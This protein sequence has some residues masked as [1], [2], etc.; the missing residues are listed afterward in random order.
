M[1]Y[2]N[3]AKLNLAIASL[4]AILAIFYD[5][6]RVFAL[7][8]FL[9][10]LGIY[11]YHAFIKKDNFTLNRKKAF[12]TILIALIICISLVVITYFVVTF[13]IFL[14]ISG[15]IFCIGGIVTLILLPQTRCDN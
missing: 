5:S 3:I 8:V 2:R 4:I 6:I 12:L 7:I 13:D 11:V 9:S 10:A 1:N 14:I 15:I